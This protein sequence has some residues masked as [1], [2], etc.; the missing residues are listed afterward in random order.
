MVLSLD[1]VEE[2]PGVNPESKRY[3]KHVD[4]ADVSL[5]SLNGTDVVPM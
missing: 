5:A 4:Q 3:L 1:V 2:F